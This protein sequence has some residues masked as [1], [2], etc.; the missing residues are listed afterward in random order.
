MVYNESDS[1]EEKKKKN[2]IQEGA[3]KRGL[4]LTSEK[5]YVQRKKE[6]QEDEGDVDMFVDDKAFENDHMM[7]DLDEMDENEKEKNSKKEG[8]HSDEDEEESEDEDD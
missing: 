7:E 6:F 5:E 1:E 4:K 3:T 2:K 8:E